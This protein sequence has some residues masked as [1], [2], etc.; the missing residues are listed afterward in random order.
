M[1]NKSKTTESTLKPAFYIERPE[2]LVNP[3]IPI[4]T[5]KG[6]EPVGFNEEHYPEGMLED[7]FGKLM[8]RRN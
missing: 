5:K 4:L 3:V 2:D 6:S 7:V 8:R 1:L